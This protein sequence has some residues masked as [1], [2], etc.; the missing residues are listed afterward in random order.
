[1]TVMATPRPTGHPGYSETLPR[2][3]ESATV[4]RRLVRTA[5]AAWGLEDQ[6]DDASLVIT[7]L[8]SNA[9]DH[10]RLPSIRVIVS[11]PTANRVR[12]GVVD[13]S[14]AVPMMRTDSNGDQLRG[15]GLVLVDALTERWGTDLYGW[16]KQVWGELKCEPAR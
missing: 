8:V 16:G 13:R 6:M 1:M 10:G 12:L 5:L 11:R 9:V 4:A 2:V 7:E 14:K 3:A 15:R